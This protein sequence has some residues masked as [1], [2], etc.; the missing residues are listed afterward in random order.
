MK[1]GEAQA[2]KEKH[3]H[4]YMKAEV[5]RQMEIITSV[6]GQLEKTQ[7]ELAEALRARETQKRS[8]DSQKIEW[9]AERAAYE[10][11]L[12]S[13][14]EKLH[15][16]KDELQETR[17]ESQSHRRNEAGMA[18]DSALKPQRIPLQR[19]ADN[20]NHSVT[21][22]TPGAIKVRQKTKKS[23]A[24]PG[25]KSAFSITPLLNRTGAPPASST[26]SADEMDEPT[27]AT[28][29][30]EIKPS[31][32]AK[33]R[34]DGGTKAQYLN[35]SGEGRRTNTRTKHTA[36]SKEDIPSRPPDH[37]VNEKPPTSPNFSRTSSHGQVPAKP[38]RRKL[39]AQR[40][41]NMFDDE[42]DELSETRQPV[43]KL[44]IPGGLQSSVPVN[45]GF[46]PLKRDR[47][48]H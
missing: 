6:S 25:D 17:R 47:R 20:N 1:S 32:R 21:I 12:Q 37:T 45:T 4:S 27:K 7:R 31:S 42:N 41:K 43:R 16:I 26:S 48:L 9:E 28:D 33:A 15:S 40:D 19:P 35:R 14:N 3:A 23:S 34:I 2:E 39:G 30:D 44:A 8:S 18:N 11:K 29:N 38:K 22:A 5:S 36:A 46:S 24:L 13:V 10:D